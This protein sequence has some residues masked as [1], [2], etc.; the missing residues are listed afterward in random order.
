MAE[1]ADSCSTCRRFLLVPALTKNQARLKDY[2]DLNYPDSNPSGIT[3][4][5]LLLSSWGR[6]LL[7]CAFVRTALT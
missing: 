6:Q 5:H 7:N 4:L 1:V 3:A 2:P